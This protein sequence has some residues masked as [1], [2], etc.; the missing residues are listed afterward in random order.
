MS[1][2]IKLAWRYL[3]GRMTRTL[4]T[5]ASVVLGVVLLV[6]LS[7]LLP[8]IASLVKSDMEASR[9]VVDIMVSREDKAF[10]PYELVDQI[11]EVPGAD[12]TIGTIERSL[13][14]PPSVKFTMPD[15]RDSSDVTL[16]IKSGDPSK[17]GDE[18]RDMVRAVGHNI[19]EG[20]EIGAEDAGKRVA[21]ITQAL[22][23]AM[24]LN[25]GDM[26]V[27]PSTQGT[28]ELEIVGIVAGQRATV[29][30]EQVYT[31]LSS[32][33]EIFNVPG[34]IDHILG[35]VPS[36]YDAPSVQAEVKA[37]LAPGYR[38]GAVSLGGSAW[39]TALQVAELIFTSFGVL[40][41][42]M[43]GLIMF[44]TFRIAV[45]QR[46]RDIG[47]LRAI[48]A[49]R[50][51]VVGTVV[52]EALIQGVLGT[53]IGILVSYALVW[54]LMPVVAEVIGE[55]FPGSDVA[56]PAFST[57]SI[58]VAVLLGVGIPLVSG[59]IPARAAGRLTPMEALRPIS[60]E[61]DSLHS[62]RRSIVA[63][64]FAVLGV[65]ILVTGSKLTGVLLVFVGVLVMTPSIIRPLASAS[66]RT[67]VFLFQGEGHVAERNLGRQPGRSALT[68]STVAVSIAVL[69][70]M[71]SFITS[72]ITGM[73][74]FLD[75]TLASDYMLFP[76]NFLQGGNYLGAS[77]AFATALSEIEGVT[78]VTSLRRADIN[79]KDLGNVHVMGLDPVVYPKISDLYFVR[80]DR[81]ESFR[82]LGEGRTAIINGLVAT[83]AKL[84]PGDAITLNTIHGPKEYEVVAEGVDFLNIE[85][86]AIY[87]SQDNAAS[88]FNLRNDALILMD[89]DPAAEKIALENRILERVKDYPSFNLSSNESLRAIQKENLQGVEIMYTFLMLLLGIPILLALANTMTTNVL[90]RTREI[91]VLRAIGSSRKQIR[92]LILAEG[93]LIAIFGTGV[94]LLAG[95]AIGWC[96]VNSL[97]FV[98]LPIPYHFPYSGLVLVVGCGLVFGALASM[99]PARRAAKQNIIEAL[100]YE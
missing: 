89:I 72:N 36:G 81:D 63:G 11:R 41:L 18:W 78:E 68:V 40:A 67:L 35:K 51:M 100:A 45:I 26:L 6:S 55:F 71:S 8:P 32:A 33:Q 39:D 75:K 60:Q 21:M 64:V 97:A 23:G 87:I 16:E 59:W 9:V 13:H 5:T 96:T 1:I 98:G 20:R 34:Q 85:M 48:G 83:Q 4:L 7:A 31:T 79:V 94:G 2:N 17:G 61:E 80:G 76:E 74:G 57:T 91:G 15:G 24:Q 77:P 47:M 65:V 27:L 73:L 37:L 70:T 99:A 29:G 84:N 43:A 52:F 44:N 90:E 56:P 95:L 69:V 38:F 30:R 86:S 3:S 54:S 28:T 88:D 49:G 10:F 42:L 66:S 14:F 53:L 92:R 46:R 22:A 12:A 82:R 25:L 93:L 62:I 50:R 58:A 19:A